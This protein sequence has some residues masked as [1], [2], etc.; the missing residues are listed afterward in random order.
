MTSARR[1][2]RFL[3]AVA[4][5]TAL[6]PVWACGGGGE[7]A[8]PTSPG[9]SLSESDVEFESFH[10]ANIARQQNQVNQLLSLEEACLRHRPPA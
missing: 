9:V 7:G 1:L 8:S 3:P 4:L 5:L 2:H 6:L 10:L